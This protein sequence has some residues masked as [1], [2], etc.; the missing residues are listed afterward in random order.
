VG[1]APVHGFGEMLRQHRCSAGFSQEYLAERSGLSATAIGIIERGL[2]KAPRPETIALLV[3]ALDLTQ[4][5]G[6]VLEALANRARARVTHRAVDST[7]L[8]HFLEPARAHANAPLDEMDNLPILSTSFVARERE[9]ANLRELIL[10]DDA[11]LITI[12]GMGGVGKSR[13]AI[14]AARGIKDGF[15]DGVWLVELGSLEDPD[16]VAAT[17]ASVLGVIERGDRP[18]Q[19]TLQ[20]ALRT[21]SLLLILDN[22]EHVLASAAGVA[23]ALTQAC[24]RVQI[25]ATSRELLRIAGERTYALVPLQ[26]AAAPKE[27]RES[28]MSFPAVQLFVRRAHEQ[29]ADA[30]DIGN[31]DLLGIMEIVRR[32]DGLPLAIELAVASLRTL[33]ISE[34]SK[35]LADRFDFL[36]A[37]DRNAPPRHQTLRGLIDWSYDR[38]VPAEQF[39]FQSCSVFPGTFTIDAMIAVCAREDLSEHR[40]VQLFSSLVD[41]SLVVLQGAPERRWSMLDSI[42]EYARTVCRDPEMYGAASRNHATHYL[43]LARDLMNARSRMPYSDVVLCLRRD[44]PSFEAALYWALHE[45]HDPEL[46]G[47]LASLLMDLFE[48]DSLS[49]ARHW[50]EKAL[51]AL[52]AT[53]TPTLVAILTVRL[54]QLL[55]YSPITLERISAI[56][57]AVAIFRESGDAQQVCL[58]LSM[59][60]IALAAAGEREEARETVVEAVDLA[61]RALTPIQ[62]SWMLRIHAVVLLEDDLE[63]QVELLEEA[64][65]VYQPQEPDAHSSIT[66]LQLGESLFFSGDS[67]SA[68]ANSLRAIDILQQ[69]PVVVQPDLALGYAKVSAYFLALNDFDRACDAA[70]EALRISLDIGDAMQTAIVLQCFALLSAVDGDFR[71]AALLSAY[72]DAQTGSINPIMRLESYW[73]R[74]ISGLIGGSLPQAQMAWLLRSGALWSEDDAVDQALTIASEL[75]TATR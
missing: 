37:G 2:R 43:E 47:E 53:A 64:L 7:P 69:F 56:R 44:R 74:H 60:G 27:S 35:R 33:S 21:R 11:R 3:A 58:A 32:L 24:P 5:Q 8:V 13:L 57:R 26:Y 62:I 59:L 31:D 61:K 6:A 66:L 41:K 55:R 65:C 68:I 67:R 34:L 19:Q 54:E 1:S 22:C 4:E 51:A 20:R 28:A 45:L 25:L 72:C 52:D 30:I 18:L 17:V 10:G 40:I 29:T 63:L 49:H 39:V 50:F 71:R 46:G 38:L 9:L 14:E 70:R 12:T 42:R 73:Q 23:A 75:Q 48:S 36:S 16:R 15:D